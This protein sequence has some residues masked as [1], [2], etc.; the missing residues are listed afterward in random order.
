MT[1]TTD[2]L[3]NGA[4][5]PRTLKP[6]VLLCIH[7]TANMGTAQQQRD[8]ANRAGSQVSAH[9]YLDPDGSGVEAID[10]AARCAWSNGLV[11]SP[12]LSIPTV[13]AAVAAGTNPNRIV[14]R[15]VECVGDAAHPVT[16]AQ[17]AQA[18][19]LVAADSR[20]TGLPV[21]RATVGTHADW[22]SVYRASCAFPPAVREAQLAAIITGANAI[23]HPAPPAPAPAPAPV[24][25]WDVSITTKTPVYKASSTTSAVLGYAYSMSAVATRQMVPA[26]N[27]R[28]WYH[29]TS[30]KLYVGGWVVADGSL[31]STPHKP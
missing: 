17:I 27:G 11:Q 3:T 16:A 12:N 14:W 5:W 8:Y 30:A 2:L 15:E 22:D 10:P 20:L 18:A 4:S 28:W 6:T 19:R 7:I 23:L 31:T 1:I 21:S 26:S 9:D 29:I 24:Q 25:L 13:K